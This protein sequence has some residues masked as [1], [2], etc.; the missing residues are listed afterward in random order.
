[1]SAIHSSGPTRSTSAPSFETRRSDALHRVPLAVGEIV[2]AEA[3]ESPSQGSARILLKGALLAARTDRI[4]TPGERFSAR[5]ESVK[6]SIILRLLA[7]QEPAGRLLSE[8]LIRYEGNPRLMSELIPALREALAQE[9]LGSLSTILGPDTVSRLQNLLSSL[10]YRGA[11]SGPDYL[12]RYMQDLGF[13]LERTLHGA[14]GRFFGRR[15]AVAEAAFT[16]KGMLGSLMQLL[17]S[18]HGGSDKN[19]EANRLLVLAESLKETIEDNQVVNA[20]LQ[21]RGEGC[22]FVMP[23]LFPGGHGSAEVAIGGEGRSQSGREEGQNVTIAMLLDALGAV[24]VAASLR[25]GGI[26]V[27][28]NASDED[29][30]RFLEEHISELTDILPAAG[31]AVTAILCEGPATAEDGRDPLGGLRLRE[32]CQ[33]LDVTA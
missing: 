6:P 25:E 28:I 27:R 10:T 30:R 3:V 31:L 5:V 14:L 21:Q 2:E 4:F 18:A 33:T 20:L 7:E 22:R 23:L 11:A 1:M 24:T 19:P 12:R 15:T 8:H 29:R 13:F 32:A 9:R 17:R 16:L 26:T